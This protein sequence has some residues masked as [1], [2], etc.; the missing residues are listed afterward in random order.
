MDK[1]LPEG[2]DLLSDPLCVIHDDTGHSGE[3]GSGVEAR[4]IHEEVKDVQW[5][6][7]MHG[8]RIA[9]RHFAY[10]RKPFPYLID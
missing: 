10:H 1:A 9:N 8:G 6:A 5:W 2:V 7:P 3:A 4:L